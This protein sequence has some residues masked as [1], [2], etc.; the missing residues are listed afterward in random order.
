MPVRY[1]EV[2]EVTSHVVNKCERFE[3][4]PELFSA[5]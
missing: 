2:S 5:T 1:F 3:G 4:D